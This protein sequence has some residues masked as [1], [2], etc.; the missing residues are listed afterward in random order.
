MLFHDSPFTISTTNAQLIKS[1]HHSVHPVAPI[2]L[3]TYFF[4]AFAS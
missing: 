2:F 1:D 3:Q 4:P